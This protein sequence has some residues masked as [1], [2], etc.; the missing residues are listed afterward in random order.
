[1]NYKQLL[2]ETKAK[3]QQAAA[4][5]QKAEEIITRVQATLKRIDKLEAEAP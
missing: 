3:Q 2:Q 1:M 4:D 5:R